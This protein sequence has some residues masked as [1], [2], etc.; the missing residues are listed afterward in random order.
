MS[1]H[2]CRDGAAWVYF[3]NFRP[4]NTI[5]EDFAAPETA[6]ED[7]GSAVLT[8][9]RAQERGVGAVSLDSYP[10]VNID[11]LDGNISFSAPDF[12]E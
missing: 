4:G 10:E 2:Y 11:W 5:N 1:G 12:S 3:E 8:F 6:C 9:N 7:I